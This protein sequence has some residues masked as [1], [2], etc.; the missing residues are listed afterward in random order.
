VIYHEI[1]DERGHAWTHQ[2]L[3]WVAFQSGDF[4]DAETQLL[5]AEERFDAIGDR[6]G[7]SWAQGLRAYVSYFLRRFD[8]AETLALAVES[9]ARRW[10]QP[11]P[12]LMMQTLL[13]NLRLWTGRLGEAEQLAERALAGFRE[14]NDRFG[15]MQALSP[16]NRARV[17]LGKKAD[18]KRGVEEAISLGHSFGELSMALQGAAGVAV[19]IGAA[20]Q[21]LDLALQVLDRHQSTGT[22][23]N[24]AWVLLAL[25]RCQNGDV[26]GAMAAIEELD[27]DDFPFGQSARALV[28]AVAGEVDGAR[29]DAEAVEQVRGAS[30][31]DLAV[32]RLGGVIAAD[33]SGDTVE[34]ERWLELFGSLASSVGDVVFMGVAQALGDRGADGDDREPPVLAP[35][36]RTIIDSTIVG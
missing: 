36:W 30:Y 26:D 32:S 31:F 2:S 12:A 33:R 14:M 18:A 4:E 20:E 10:G 13:A 3:A 8:D 11:W 6:S 24:E 35:G 29:A 22:T 25:A 27:V 7:V 19:H 15:V 17:G 9:E 5:E 34:S 21:A 1:D 28:R 23:Q 16:L